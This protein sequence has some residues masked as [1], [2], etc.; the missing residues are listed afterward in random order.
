MENGIRVTDLWL[1]LLFDWFPEYFPGQLMSTPVFFLPQVSLDFRAQSIPDWT[2]LLK[3]PSIVNF[4]TI[5]ESQ[6][7]EFSLIFQPKID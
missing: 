6:I 4:M 1:K 2:E 5:L 3:S 7:L